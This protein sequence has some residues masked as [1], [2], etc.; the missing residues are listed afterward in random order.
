MKLSTTIVT[1]FLQGFILTAPANA[2][3]FPKPR[4]LTGNIVNDIAA[5]RQQ[6]TAAITGQP[7]PDP[8][9]AL[10]CDFKMLTKLTP[11]HLVP[12]MKPCRSDVNQTLV[13]DTQRALTS[14][15]AYGCGPSATGCTGDGDG[16]NCLTP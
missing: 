7:A 8:S 3:T 11:E 4:P 12:T 14:A 10:P 9:A 2:Q 13:N 5:A 6:T 1:L 16:V 15:Q